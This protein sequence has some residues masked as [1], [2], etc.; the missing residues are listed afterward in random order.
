MAGCDKGLLQKRQF[1]QRSWCGA[2]LG[3]TTGFWCL[4]SPFFFLHS[5]APCTS[6]AHHATPSALQHPLLSSSPTRTPWQP[7][8]PPGSATPYGRQQPPGP[9]S[10]TPVATRS[11]S[12]CPTPE[13]TFTSLPRPSLPWPRLLEFTHAGGSTESAHRGWGAP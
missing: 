5:Q 4:N 9:H 12:A 11:P 10:A 1:M 13:P 2:P 3:C 8:D 7:C 6:P